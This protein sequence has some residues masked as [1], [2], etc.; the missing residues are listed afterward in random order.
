MVTVNVVG[1]L[2]L[3]IIRRHL[4]AVIGVDVASAA[5]KDNH[6]GRLGRATIR[7]N[8][9]QYESKTQEPTDGLIVHLDVSL[10]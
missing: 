4:K 6:H 8:G 1:E 10:T 7:R 2:R 5:S 9:T 3:E